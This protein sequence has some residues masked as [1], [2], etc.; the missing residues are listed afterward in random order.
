MSRW[1]EEYLEAGAR[2]DINIPKRVKR[3]Y[4]LLIPILDGKDNQWYFNPKLAQRP[5]DFGER[6]CR[7]SKDDWRGRPI[8]YLLWQKAALSAIYGIVDRETDLRRFR[9]VFIEVGKKNG[10][11]TMT[12]PIALYE[13]AKKGN[14][15][16]CAANALQ[17]ARIIWT[18]AVN[19]L[20]QSPQLQTLLRARQ[21]HIQN[22][23]KNGFSKF[24]PL[25]NVPNMLDGKMPKFVIL[26]EVHELQQ[27]IYDILYQGQI[28][29]TEPML[30]MLTTKGYVREG[31]FDSEYENSCQ[32]LDG[33]IDD[34]RKF[35]LLYELDNPQDWLNED[36]WQQANPSMGMLFSRENLRE[37]VQTAL[38]KPKELNAVKVKHFN[39]G[40]VSGDAYFS[41]DEIENKR[42]FSLDRFRGYDAIG[43]FDLS[44]TNDL[45]SFT[46]LFWDEKEREFCAHTKFWVSQSFYDQASQDPR[47]GRTWRVWVERG[48]VEI[49]GINSIAH[50]AITR[51]VCKMVEKYNI[52]YR[53]IY[54][55]A[56][57]ARYLVDD[58]NEQGFREGACLIRCQQGSKTLSVP[59]QR[60]D[61]ELRARK[62]NYQNNPVM[63]WYITNVAVQEDL[64][65]KNL[66]PC[67]AGHNNARKIDGFATLLNA[68][69]GVMDH[70][71]EFTGEE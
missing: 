25:A 3:Q 46:T 17:Q 32:I 23:R 45:T 48:L 56:Y 35:S 43:G 64:R 50:Q 5:I 7:Q 36:N 8:E 10:K 20:E 44:L 24:M 11:T 31:L 12:A 53:W 69:V 29:I 62:I 59:F 51:H 52:C 2:G 70:Y 54:Y 41:L 22:I 65:N 63:K 58:L 49:A 1:I 6:F 18:E 28:S 14:E 57:A 55:D 61:A 38:Q 37:I 71:K 47:M 15:V 34:Q 16:Y 13:T 21:Y 30:F 33:V 60:L 9:R 19:M 4:E 67:K 42:T 68:F 26:D 40:G 39:I 66:L 27:D